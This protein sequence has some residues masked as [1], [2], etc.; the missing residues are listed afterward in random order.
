MENQVWQVFVVRAGLLVAFLQFCRS[1]CSFQV[2]LCVGG[3]SC[4]NA[5]TQAQHAFDERRV[6]LREKV[7]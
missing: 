1:V 3:L 2:C 7:G 5:L 4:F 6:E